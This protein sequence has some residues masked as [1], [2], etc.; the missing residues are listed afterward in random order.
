MY[1]SR[2]DWVFG[3]PSAEGKLTYDTA[4]R[5]AATLHQT[6]FVCFIFRAFSRAK[7]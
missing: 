3:N 2:L 5:L 1:V 4:F 7:E 6:R